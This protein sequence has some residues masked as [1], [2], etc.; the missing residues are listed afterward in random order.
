VREL[1]WNREIEV[2]GPMGEK[3][4]AIAW[5][6]GG[7]VKLSVVVPLVKA[8]RAI[9]FACRNAAAP[10]RRAVRAATW[11]IEFMMNADGIE[12]EEWSLVML[13][14]LG[15]GDGGM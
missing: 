8:R 4:L 15:R 2:V 7:E 6:R 13:N 1:G 10:L 12:D 5:W 11:A 9:G 3:L 14:L